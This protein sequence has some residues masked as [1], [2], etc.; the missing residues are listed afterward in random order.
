[1][2]FIPLHIHSQYSILNSTASI[3]DLVDKAKSLGYSALALTD[4][5]NMYGAVEFFKACKEAKIK[6]L[7]GCELH[8]APHHRTDKKRIPGSPAG[9][10]LLIYAKNQEGYRNLCKLSS[11]AHLEGFYYTP[12]IDKELLAK[13]REGLICLSGPLQ[14]LIPFLILQGREQEL[15]KEIEWFQTLFGEDFYLQ[16]ERHPMSEAD[17]ERDGMEKEGWLLQNYRDYARNQEVVLKNL[18]RSEKK[19]T[20]SASQPRR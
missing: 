18:L 17:I 2:G 16:I 5:G 12:R 1:M 20:S 3:E 14:G 6:P 11:A 7:L 8:L 15:A 10:P 9:F 13:H 4:E 19:K